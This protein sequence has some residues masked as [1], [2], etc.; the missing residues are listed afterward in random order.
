MLAILNLAN[1][2]DEFFTK[3]IKGEFWLMLERPA[4]ILVSLGKIYFALS[5][6]MDLLLIWKH[7][8]E[9]SCYVTSSPHPEDRISL[10]CILSR[11]FKVILKANIYLTLFSLFCISNAGVNNLCL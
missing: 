7:L 10:N 2:N 1:I 9:N 6:A 4:A 5:A 8:V 11:C 3:Q